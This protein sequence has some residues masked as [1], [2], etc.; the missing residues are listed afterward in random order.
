MSPARTLKPSPPEVLF[1][2]GSRAFELLWET[3]AGGHG[4]RHFH[5]LRRQPGKDPVP[6]FLQM[7]PLVG[8]FA[9][10]LR[11]PRARMRETVE[12]ARLLQHRR[13]A[14]LLGSHDVESALYLEWED[15][16]GFTLEDVSLLPLVYVYSYSESFLL[17]VGLQLASL[18]AFM[19]GATDARGMPLGFVHR[20]LRP[21]GIRFGLDGSLVLTD[22]GDV[23]SRLPGRI[24][25]SATRPHGEVYYAAPEV[26]FGEGADARSD[27]FSLGLILLEL[28]TSLH[29]YSLPLVLMGDLEARLSEEDTQRMLQGM[30]VASQAGRGSWE[31]SDVLTHA[32]AYRPEDVESLMLR[33]SP[34][35]KAILHRLLRRERSERYPTAEALVEDLRAR[36]DAVDG[37]YGG[38]DAA[39]EFRRA[40]EKTLPLMR[41]FR[42]SVGAF[43]DDS[44]L[45][46]P[47]P[48]V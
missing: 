5:A 11:D 4:E 26:L 39:L 47:T 21:R 19:H 1:K 22:L 46:L 14:K 41:A 30:M 45:A 3:R 10:F 13:I 33:Q 29:L 43:T 6:V 20:D 40:L 23:F 34:G 44:V 27:L 12:L 36:A 15:V 8:P 9:T 35:L 7:L 2:T 42:R 25:S 31:Y 18:L 38:A 37:T 28:A 24:P 17:H 32:A 48:A 16:R